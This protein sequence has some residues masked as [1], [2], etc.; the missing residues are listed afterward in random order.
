[1][2]DGKFHKFHI[3]M[4]IWKTVIAVFIC[5][6]LGMIFD[7]HPFYSMIAAILCMQA[8]TSE[9][10]KKGVIRCIGTFIGGFAAVLIL[11]IIDFTPLKPFS[12]LYYVIISLCI[13]PIIYSTVLL[14]RESSA[15]IS[16]VVF[17]SIV[18]SHF[19]AQNH[20]L[21]ALQRVLETITGIVTA[22]IVNKFIK[23]PDKQTDKSDGKESDEN[24]N[25]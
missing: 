14:N 6:V 13:A 9:S 12:V 25:I 16:C 18:L 21:F 2:S 23:N 22:I 1:M 3:G 8:N 20:Y 11:L 5:A 7:I 17:L 4:R 19:D 15:F 10:I 24:E